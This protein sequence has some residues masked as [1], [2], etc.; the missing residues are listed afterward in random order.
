MNEKMNDALNEISDQHIQEAAKG[1]RKPKLRWIGAVAAVLAA[2]IL[3]GVLYPLPVK[4]AVPNFSVPIGTAPN[5]YYFSNLVATPDYPQLSQYPNLS[6]VEDDDTYMAEYE[7]W[8]KSQQ[9]QYDQPAGYADSLQDFFGRS[10][11]QFLSGEGNQAYSPVNLYLAMA[12]L[13]QSAEG[14]SR[15][16]ILDLLG[17]QSIDALREQAG[18]VWNA[19]YSNDGL[20][21]LLLANSLWLD[22]AYRFHADTVDTLADSYYASVFHAN[23]GTGEVNQQLRD[24]LNTNTGGLLTQQAEQTKLSEET[25]AALASTIYFSAQWDEKF[26]KSATVHQPFYSPDGETTASFMKTT[27]SNALYYWGEDFSAIRLGLSGGNSMW[28][29]LPDQ[30]KTPQDLLES[31]ACISL[32]QNTDSWEDKGNYKIHLSLPKFDISSQADLINGMKALGITDVFDPSTANLTG[33]IDTSTTAGN[34]YV[35]KI[36]HA[37]RVTIDEDGCTAAA[38]TVI[39]MPSSGMPQEDEITFT[40][41]RPFLFFITSRDALPLFAGLVCNP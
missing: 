6:Q 24:W 5:S 20:S 3:I 1:K 23:L 12:M 7:A 10:I 17:V 27:F 19:H 28:L 34:P 41:D 8:R 40:L 22:D 21:T 37:V 9:D 33:L 18:H 30:G 38:Y 36:D 39:G 26:S 14:T 25:A 2:A 35:D 15:Q 13:A 31:G 29:I 11:A 16:Q 4:P 32:L